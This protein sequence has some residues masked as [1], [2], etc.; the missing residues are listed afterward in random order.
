MPEH[1]YAEANIVVQASL[2][3][4]S[5]WRQVEKTGIMNGMHLLQLPE[6]LLLHDL[7]DVAEEQRSNF[8]RGPWVASFKVI[9]F[10]SFYY[11]KCFLCSTLLAT[12]SAVTVY[13][14][15]HCVT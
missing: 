5:S 15:L 6:E 7:N 11:R 10:A 4:V 9:W 14:N 8:L 1:Q 13:R 3:C 12:S 2:Q